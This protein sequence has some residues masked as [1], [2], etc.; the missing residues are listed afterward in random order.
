MMI[1]HNSYPKLF[2]V[3]QLEQSQSKWFNNKYISYLN[4]CQNIFQMKL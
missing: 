3:Y 1:Q 4:F 2:I